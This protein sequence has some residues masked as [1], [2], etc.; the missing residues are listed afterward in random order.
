M[1]SSIVQ[2][3]T[4]QQLGYYVVL[5]AHLNFTTCALPSPPTRSR[6]S[7]TRWTLRRVVLCHMTTSSP[8]QQSQNSL[9][10]Q[11]PP[12]SLQNADPCRPLLPPTPHP[13]HHPRPTPCFSLTTLISQC[14]AIS[15][16]P[17]RTYPSQRH[18]SSCHP[19][20]Q[21]TAPRD[22]LRSTPS[23]ATLPRQIPGS[24]S[25]HPSSNTPSSSG[26]QVSDAM[27]CKSLFSLPIFPTHPFI[28]TIA[29]RR[30]RILHVVADSWEPEG[31]MSLSSLTFPI[32]SRSPGHFERRV[33]F[34]HDAELAQV[35]AEFDGEM[36]RITVPRRISAVSC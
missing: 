3:H 36:L 7:K 10:L 33:S 18:P 16:E 20:P 19:N 25:K 27:E 29:T 6:T 13:H 11:T 1:M 12:Q 9:L 22:A 30:R 14:P 34:G 21:S 24:Q 4:P 8:S 26:Y 28:R 23:S 32:Y 35:R 31:G 15:P 5:H 2:F 17:P